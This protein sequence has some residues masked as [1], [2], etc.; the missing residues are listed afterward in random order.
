VDLPREKYSRGKIVPHLDLWAWTA[1]GELWQ[2]DD[3]NKFQVLQWNAGDLKQ[4]KKT[5]L[6]KT[7]EDEETDGFAIVREENA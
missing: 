4:A 7:L 3:C 2:K 6:C 5:E 1:M